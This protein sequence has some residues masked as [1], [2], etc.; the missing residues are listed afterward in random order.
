MPLKKR[1]G[2]AKGCIPAELRIVLRNQAEH[3]TPAGK[4][5]MRGAYVTDAK[6]T[7]ALGTATL[8]AGREYPGPGH[9]LRPT[10]ITV[11]NNPIPSLRVLD[12]DFRGEGGRAWKVETPE[13][14]Y[15]DLREDV[16]I[17]CLRARCAM[18]NSPCGGLRIYGPFR[19]VKWGSQMRLALM[20]SDLYREIA[21][22]GKTT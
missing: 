18:K 3:M 2:T 8:W 22:C 14:F 6:S 11:K 20:D 4:F 15:V 17:E 10:I 5:V 9:T 7:A 13:G 12:I 21:A 1:Y 19:W 16:F